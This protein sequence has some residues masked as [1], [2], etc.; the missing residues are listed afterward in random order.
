MLL[1]REPGDGYM[2]E[3]A[4]LYHK[5]AIFQVAFLGTLVV[6]ILSQVFW[7]VMYMHVA[8]PTILYGN[9]AV[10]TTE[11]P[12]TNMQ[13][14]AWEALRPYLTMDS[15]NV[16]NDLQDS[17]RWMTEAM[18]TR[19]DRDLG[20]YEQKF[21]KSYAQA[22][23]EL[24]VQTQFGTVQSERLKDI[25]VD[26]VRKYVVRIY[27]DLT[28]LSKTR[29]TGEPAKFDYIVVLER[30][31]VSKTNPSGLLVSDIRPTPAKGTDGAERDGQAVVPYGPGTA[32]AAP[33]EEQGR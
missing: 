32:P 28:R 2:P 10:L 16:T 18:V 14:L 7:F 1:H 26:G 5:A 21:K 29:G 23:A 9:A 27:G 20:A 11:P 4:H 30:A 13:F 22:V 6:F 17:K 24:G 8:N 25:E 12:S 33:A 15:A 3:R 31:P 19:M